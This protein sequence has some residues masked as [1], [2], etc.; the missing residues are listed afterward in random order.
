MSNPNKDLSFEPIDYD[1]VMRMAREGRRLQSIAVRDM[2]VRGYKALMHVL[3]ID[4][5]ASAKAG[6]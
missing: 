3:H 1:E 5:T 6:R 2:I 4:N